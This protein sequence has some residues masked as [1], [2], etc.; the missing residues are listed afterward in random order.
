MTDEQQ[1]TPAPEAKTKRTL[2]GD[3]RKNPA[4]TFER[5]D[6]LLVFGRNLREWRK[7]KKLSRAKL[8]KMIGCADVTLRFVE[9]PE[10]RAI[11]HH[12]L[13]KCA[14]ALGVPAP[15]LMLD[16]NDLQSLMMHLTAI[17]EVED[18][19]LALSQAI[20]ERRGCVTVPPAL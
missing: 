9:S 20:A 8:A 13:A 14:L 4:Q 18:V 16:T 10:P 2:F 15:I 6:Y 19:L 7:K 5:V 1:T 3:W 11:R 17:H 12:L